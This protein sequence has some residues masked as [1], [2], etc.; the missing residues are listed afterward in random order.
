[1]E[2]KSDG[3]DGDLFIGNKDLIRYIFGLP[4]NGITRQN[5]NIIQQSLAAYS[6]FLKVTK[7]LAQ[8][9][10]FDAWKEKTVRQHF[11]EYGCTLLALKELGS[12]IHPIAHLALLSLDDW[13]MDVHMSKGGCPYDSIS[14]EWK[15]LYC[16]G[17]TVAR[18]DELDVAIDQY[19]QEVKGRLGNERSAAGGKKG[20]Q[21][22]PACIEGIIMDACD[23]VNSGNFIPAETE[24]TRLPRGAFTDVG[25]HT[26]G[27]ERE[28]AW[29]LARAI[30]G[31]FLQ[32]SSPPRNAPM[33]QYLFKREMLDFQR[34]ILR[35]R[36]E[37]TWWNTGDINTESVDLTVQ[38]IHSIARS[39][40]ELSE[41]GYDIGSLEVDLAVIRE[42]LDAEVKDRDE[43]AAKAYQL[44]A[45]SVLSKCID[46]TRSP[47]LPFPVKVTIHPSVANLAQYRALALDNL[48]VFSLLKSELK[49]D[50]CPEVLLWL[51]SEEVNDFQGQLP[52][53]LVLQTLEQWIFSLAGGLSSNDPLPFAHVSQ[54]EEIV[55]LYRGHVDAFLKSELAEARMATEMLSKETLVVWTSYALIEDAVRRHYPTLMKPYGVSLDYRDLHH[56]VLCDKLSSDASLSV[57]KYLHSKSMQPGI[58]RFPEDATRWMAQDFC[59]DDEIIMEI[60]AK[61]KVNADD[62]RKYQWEE[63]QRKK[64]LYASLD[65]QLVI[66]KRELAQRTAEVA[67]AA[68]A[69]ELMY[70]KYS[71]EYREAQ[72]K[73]SKAENAE[74]IALSA[75]KT[76][77]QE[78]EEADKPPPAVFQPL[79]STESEALTALFALY[80]PSDFRTLSRMSFM[81]QQ[82]LLPRAPFP[83]T[84]CITKVNKF[85][86]TWVDHY[87]SMQPVVE[88]D[89]TDPKRLSSVVKHNRRNPG[90]WGSSGKVLFGARKGRPVQQD[91]PKSVRQYNYDSTG[92]W[93]PN[94]MPELGWRGGDFH[95]D[96]V[97]GCFPF[98]PCYIDPWVAPSDEM[99]RIRFYTARAVD[100]EFQ[101]AFYMIPSPVPHRGNS[102]IAAAS[103]HKLRSLSAMQNRAMFTLRERPL[104]QARQLHKVLHDRS[105]PFENPDVRLIVQQLLYQIGCIEIL[106]TNNIPCHASKWD[107]LP[108]NGDAL[109]AIGDELLVLV[110]ELA[111]R[112]RDHEQLLL[113]IDIATYIRHWSSANDV[114]ERV[115]Q[116][117]VE[118][119]QGFST[120]VN[121]EITKKMEASDLLDIDR[122]K[123][124]HALFSMYTVLAYGGTFDLKPADVG[125]LLNAKV[126]AFYGYVYQK[127]ARD[128]TKF[129]HLKVTSQ[130]V[131][132]GRLEAVLQAI[133]KDGRI[134]SPAVDQI[135]KLPEGPHTWIP[136]DSDNSSKTACF[137]QASN[138]DDHC[139][140]WTNVKPFDDLC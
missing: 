27:L 69:L 35:N 7:G 79:P 52:S 99:T 130:N 106:P 101:P 46:S 45:A 127:D 11:P 70:D 22:T 50:S 109:Q 125:R 28:T 122:L 41:G 83:D 5:E 55:E 139:N 123:A 81:A 38:M 137:D 114:A 117:C 10:K 89:M 61:E 116:R 129:G 91:F 103:K 94:S 13:S 95:L 34:C 133:E 87:N 90:L 115:H 118:A 33:D 66:L 18:L 51:Q 88:Y 128:A 126:S 15:E 102:A 53:Q 97:F 16:G 20:H 25:L 138:S 96:A 6:S 80:M 67:D 140:Q 30:I 105:L 60:W 113:M 132:D 44:P 57:S 21:K 124:D 77:V 4:L 43:K 26:G 135:I 63:I 14:L 82:M 108:E 8:M 112:L 62:R 48:G 19:L 54:L 71:I 3:H 29:P 136:V 17:V 58:F 40:A 121:D 31:T 98:D 39:G 110:D 2:R 73:K 59:R 74:R 37:L 86:W 85:N 120:H 111:E 100:S 36:K 1:M 78:M 84:T 72:S 68:K 65:E 42:E 134:L 76:K 47:K 75:V 93:H 24:S 92:V 23:D 12:S 56:L 119:M 64:A 107:L 49:V 104:L 9:E 131:M 32:Q